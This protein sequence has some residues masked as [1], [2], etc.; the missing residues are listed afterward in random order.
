MEDTVETQWHPCWEF[1]NNNNKNRIAEATRCP[2]HCKQ[3]TA[4]SSQS[5]A[6]LGTCDAWENPVSRFR[7]YQVTSPTPPTKH[8][9]H[10]TAPE[11][12]PGSHQWPLFIHFDPKLCSSPNRNTHF[13]VFFCP[14]RI[15]WIIRISDSWKYTMFLSI[16]YYPGKSVW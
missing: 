12:H 14:Q 1:K 4:I 10:R 8:G 13:S 15:N 2:D 3:V 9:S 7:I 5:Q 16:S 6:F 11:T